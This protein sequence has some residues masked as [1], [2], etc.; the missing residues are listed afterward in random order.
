MI[1]VAEHKAE[2]VRVST[3]SYASYVVR[4]VMRSNAWW[5]MLLILVA[6]VASLFDYRY[7]LV[8]FMVLL[9]ATPML[10][11]LAYMRYCLDPTAR[12]SIL[13]KILEF[14]D[15]AMC[16]KIAILDDDEHVTNRLVYD[17]DDFESAE[18]SS[19]LLVLK[20]KNFKFIFFMIPESALTPAQEQLIL[21]YYAP[22]EVE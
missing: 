8:A 16:F 1:E 19:N 10:I 22:L 5:I 21:N 14:D 7:I 15:S 18:V 4:E 9:I 11:G 13:P 20:F 17:M 12:Y 6:A 3:S 2:P